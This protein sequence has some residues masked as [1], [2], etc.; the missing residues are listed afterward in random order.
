MELLCFY[1]YRLEIMC[2]KC[3][4][5][6]SESGQLVESLPYNEQSTGPQGLRQA[7]NR[8]GLNRQPIQAGVPENHF[9]WIVSGHTH[10]IITILI[11]KVSTLLFFLKNIVFLKFWRFFSEINW[12]KH[13]IFWK[14]LL[15]VIT[16]WGSVIFLLFQLTKK[17]IP[18][19][20]CR[21][22]A[23]LTNS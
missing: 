21:F 15:E 2:T 16:S 9:M 12:M 1:S 14:T 20:F 11:L 23:I 4:F 17:S 6:K 18:K 5:K 3:K 13:L 8:F 7:E 22:A 10:T 19:K